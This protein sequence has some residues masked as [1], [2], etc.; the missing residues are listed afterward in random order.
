MAAAGGH[1]PSTLGALRADGPAA[2]TTRQ[3]SVTA[4]AAHTPRP[5]QHV[6]FPPPSS[7]LPPPCSLLPAP[8]SRTHR[9]SSSTAAYTS[10]SPALTAD[11][12]DSAWSKLPDSTAF[13]PSSISSISWAA[14]SSCRDRG[15]RGGGRGWSCGEGWRCK[16]GGLRRASAAA[17]AAPWDRRAAPRPR[18]R[19]VFRACCMLA[20]SSS[21]EGLTSP[22]RR[23]VV[24]TT[25]APSLPAGQCGHRSALRPGRRHGR[26]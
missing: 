13:M 23:R 8:S 24:V 22:S 16:R 25:S 20:I 10:R 6:P 5:R 11:L 9:M 1:A 21:K 15:G 18:G 4:T 26:H 3:Q 7:L 12:T 17:G 2:A 19:T 14:S